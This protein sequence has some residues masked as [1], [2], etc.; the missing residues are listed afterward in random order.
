[1][2]SGIMNAGTDDDNVAPR[3]PK[4]WTPATHVHFEAIRGVCVLLVCIC[5][6]RWRY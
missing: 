6:C 2:R 1:M 4:H 5:Q 3:Q